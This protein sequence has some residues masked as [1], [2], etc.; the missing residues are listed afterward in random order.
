MVVDAAGLAVAVVVACAVVCIVAVRVATV[1]VVAVVTAGIV[2]A[3]RVLRELDIEA[4]APV[5]D[6]IARPAVDGWGFS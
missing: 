4:A 6:G 2:L 5:Q 3:P 1:S